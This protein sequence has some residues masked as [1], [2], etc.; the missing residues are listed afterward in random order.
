MSIV[1]DSNRV[2]VSYPNIPILPPTAVAYGE[3]INT[4]RND[5]DAVDPSIAIVQSRDMYLPNFSI[6]V[7]EGKFRKQAVFI[8]KEGEGIDL[9]G[10]CVFLKGNVQTQLPRCSRTT[11][12]SYDRS[13]NFKYDPNNEF[14]HIMP[15]EN[16]F[17][18]MHFSMSLKH[19]G[20]FLPEN[21]AWAEALKERVHKGERI[22]GE[23]FLPITLLQERALQTILHC[24]LKG[25]LGWSMIETSIIQFLILQLS[26]HFPE[27]KHAVFN[28]MP[29]RDVEI[30]HTVKEF[31]FDSFLDDHC[32]H[33]LALRFGI[34][35][36]KLMITFKK[37]FGL[38]VFEYLN[39]LRMAY[40]RELLLEGSMSVAEVAHK[41]GYKNPNHF[42]TA[43]RKHYDVRPSDYCDR[44]A[45]K[46]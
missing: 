14:L 10:T 45:A 3:F 23:R 32:L 44:Y 33:G 34:N 19:F 43:F 37:V 17:H 25:K 6:R 26:A 4:P 1:L 40:A 39:N 35:T 28:G 5:N 2:T 36:N 41:I 9:L 18:F 24:P 46:I 29:K 12:E 16:E 42:S 30:I 21:E 31:L 13:H 15:A 8:N 11:I 7:L 20:A 22:A 38:S 27:Q